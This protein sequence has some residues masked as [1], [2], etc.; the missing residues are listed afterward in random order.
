MNKIKVIESTNNEYPKNLLKISKYPKKLYAIGNINL[1]T[2]TSIAI[3]GSRDC[4]KYGYVQAMKFSKEISKHGIC[5]I[6]GLAIGIDSAAHLGAS[7]EIGRTIA[8]LGGGFETKYCEENLEVFNT[9]LNNDGCIV[10]EYE[11]G[12]EKNSKYFPIRNRI[13]SGISEGV[14]I[15]E[16]KL[17]SG[18][19]IT[20]RYAKEQEKNLFCIPSNLDVKNGVGTNRLI[21]SGAKLVVTPQDILKE[22]NINNLKEENI[23]NY[24]NEKIINEEYKIVYNVLLQ[25]PQNINNISKKCGLNI[26]E[27]TQILTMLEIENLVQRLPGNEFSKI[28]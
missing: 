8:V 26:I 18:S 7:K 28:E 5:I 24:E 27:T 3:V 20:A 16:A 2:Q 25:M 21:Q 19:L 17:K 12:T 13:I 9:I 1:L 4:T 6:S 10:T 23:E 15:V 11:P 14:L 22:Y